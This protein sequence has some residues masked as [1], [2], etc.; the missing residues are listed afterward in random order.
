MRSYAS[1]EQIQVFPLQIL[2]RIIVKPLALFL[3]TFRVWPGRGLLPNLEP[4]GERLLHSKEA[5][6]IEIAVI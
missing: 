2:K 4:A 1:L 3:I 5:T 6:L